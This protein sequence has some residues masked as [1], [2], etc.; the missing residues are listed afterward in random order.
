M[1]K[2]IQVTK[3]SIESG[4]SQCIITAMIQDSRGFIW[5]GT[6]SGL[7]RFDGSRFKVYK[8]D[9]NKIHSIQ[10]NYVFA[11]REN[12]KGN[13]FLGSYNS[14]LMEY[15]YDSDIFLKIDMPGCDPKAYIS[16]ITED[17]S[18]NVWIGTSKSGLYRL[19]KDRQF[20]NRYGTQN[21]DA[22]EIISSNNVSSLYF[23]ESNSKLYIG[24]ITGGM[25][26]LDLK[27][28]KISCINF[29]EHHPESDWINNVT[30]IFRDSRAILWI[31]THYGLF[32]LDED[33]YKL[34]SVT[35]ENFEKTCFTKKSVSDICED[36]QGKLWISTQDRG[37]F[38][39][40]CTDNSLVRFQYDKNIESGLICNSIKCLLR[41]RSNVIW[42]GT[43]G[44]G[45]G[46]ID[47]QQNEFHHLINSQSNP[48][49]REINVVRSIYKDS[50]ENYW[51]GTF[52][53]GLFKLKENENNSFH[54]TK[55]EETEKNKITCIQEDSRKNIWITYQTYGICCYSLTEDKFTFRPLDLYTETHNA[56]II[57]AFCRD[58]KNPDLVWLGSAR[59]G[60]SKFDLKEKKTID[61]EL[62]PEA[63]KRI[64][65]YSL[66]IDSDDSIWIGTS[67]N[68][69]YK[70]EPGTNRYTNYVHELN[71]ANSLSNNTVNYICENSKKELWIGTQNGLN[72]LIREKLVFVRYS[73]QDGL[74]DNAILGMLTDTED[75]LWFS[76]Y[77]GLS[78]L[79]EK[80][81][82]I[83]NYFES[84]GIRCKEFNMGAFFRSV[85]GYLHFG[86][87]HGTVYFDPQKIRD[88]PHVP[89]IVLTD[90][91]IFNESI[92]P[93]TE[94]RFLKEN[95]VSAKEISL[96]YRE[97]VFSFEFAAL[98]FNNPEK[99]NYAYKME[100]FD[101]DWVYC[102]TRRQ[103]TYTNLD[104]GEYVFRVKASNNDNVWNEEGTSI[105]IIITP[106]YWK[107]WWFKGFGILSMLTA[108]GMTY[109]NRI[110]KIKKEKKQQEDFS[111]MLMSSQETERKRIAN[112]LHDSV[113]HEI[114]LLKNN[115]VNA[116]NTTKD[117]L[118]KTELS[119]ISE[120]SA[121][122]LNEVRN[123]SYNLHPHQIE[124]LGITKAI[125]SIVN[126][127]LN[128]IKVNFITDLENID[129]I[130]SEEEEVY[131][132]RI[133]QEAIS[134][135]IK[136]SNSAEAIIKI[137][138]TKES[139]CILISDN[140]EGF[141][142]AKAGKGN[143][144]LSGI[145]ERV[146]ML[147]G[148]LN[149]ESGKGEGTLMKILIPVK[150][151]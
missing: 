48:G 97:S 26:I 44:E 7:N 147:G 131:I 78:K 127:A 120:Q 91:K 75:N 46:K 103:A 111:R 66:C 49:N 27:N 110:N 138:C 100:G 6:Q 148:R 57:Y 105:N 33:T 63:L 45:L 81:N 62:I 36:L 114:L 52:Y 137:S 67:G 24:T 29:K 34:L 47:R 124:A 56:N 128:S 129:K 115:A 94:N 60:L 107:T 72:K 101:K 73:K 70:Y 5:L 95:I 102:G 32:R 4:L 11:L 41:D 134:N 19:N 125:K 69:L 71:N 88:N 96:S 89:D 139:V 104:P 39:Y 13:I 133:I 65:I 92:L 112:E 130:F 35:N 136:H 51:I 76:N 141:E 118:T 150:K 55:L 74:T 119:R 85:E 149:I 43:K 109:K 22:D 3:Y 37:L 145:S 14:V 25:N 144:G 17:S 28:N 61:T 38:C 86:G 1:L 90:F 140:G 50:E 77:F 15:I 108:T 10:D 98:I 20:V 59:T 84:D 123:I 21:S 151:Q 64:T 113:A 30:F 83:R 142:K 93:S 53:D 121:E 31:G 135:I 106:P 116:M 80:K 143:L 18:G 99:N 122:T 54:F 68:G 40:G 126:N 82:S 9:L 79:S 8:G 132:Y 58:M 146:K 16:D 117:P 42:I 12:S 23:N 87:T 2:E